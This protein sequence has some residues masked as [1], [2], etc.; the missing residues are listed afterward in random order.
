MDSDKRDKLLEFYFNIRSFIGIYEILDDKYIIYADYTDAGEFCLHL[1]CMDPSNNLDVCLKKARAAIFFSATLLP[2]RYYMDQLAGKEDDYAIYA[3]SP[4]STNNRLLMIGRDVSTKYTRRGHTEYTKIAEYIRDFA[5]AKKGNYLVFFPSY[6]MMNDICIYL[7]EQYHIHISDYDIDALPPGTNLTSFA[8]NN[9]E[10]CNNTSDSIPDIYLQS[11]SMNED[12]RE[13]FLSHF[14]DTPK[15]TTLGM[16]VMGGIFGE[17]I[18]LKDSRLIGAVIVGTG[19]P[20]VCTENELFREYFD[21]CNGSGFNYAYQYPGMNKV[22]QAAG[23]VIRTD[24]DRGAIL[25]L[26]ERF[27]QSSYQNLFPKEWF[28][29]EIVNRISMSDHLR[30]FWER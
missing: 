17:G 3:P 7:C 12:E 22:L 26:D 30:R 16:C 18:D 11:S 10:F 25:L 2:V 13:E 19:L 8:E 24:S 5:A 14:E 15:R 9:E 29:H 1:Q 27:L 28:P 23:R 21:A 20:M 6:K 4:F